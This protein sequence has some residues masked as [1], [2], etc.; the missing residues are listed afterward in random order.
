MLAENKTGVVPILSEIILLSNIQFPL[1]LSSILKILI[2][3]FEHIQ[4]PQAFQNMRLYNLDSLGSGFME[5]TL[6]AIAIL[7]PLLFALLLF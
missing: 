4:V 7:V 1:S 5:T 3:T 2:K 6:E